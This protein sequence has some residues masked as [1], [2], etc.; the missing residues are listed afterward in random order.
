MEDNTIENFIADSF[1]SFQTVTVHSSPTTIVLDADNFV[2]R[3]DILEV[4]LHRDDIKQFDK[5][6]ING[7]TFIKEK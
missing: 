1:A 3:D 6:I 2:I 7:I 4:E 5:I